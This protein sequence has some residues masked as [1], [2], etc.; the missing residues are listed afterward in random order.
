MKRLLED[1]K[2]NC[3]KQ[4]YLLCGEEAYL[5]LQY[6]DRLRNALA[7]PGDTM[8]YHYFEGKDTNPAELIDLSETVPFFAERRVIFVENSGFFKKTCEQLADY[9]KQLPPTTYFVF[10]ETEVDKRGKLYKAV[11]DTGRVVEFSSQDEETLKK[12][13]LSLIRKEGKKIS[14]AT[15]HYFLQKT[16]TDMGNIRRELEKVFC[17]TLDREAILQED[18]DAVCTR[19]V[20]NQIFD[21]VD[22]IAL[23][24]Q[25]EALRLYYDLLSLKEKP[26]RIL[27]LVGRQFNLLLQVKE[28]RKKGYAGRQIAEKTAIPVFFVGKYISQASAFTEAWLRDALEACVQADEAVKTGR[29]GD[30]MSVE[31][32]LISYSGGTAGNQAARH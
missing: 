2:N 13:V 4:V 30:V 27:A 1:I 10:I 6:R 21:M 22:A 26:M 15:L 32:L 20:S 8:N 19:L 29:L 25:Q 17:Y 31:L 5:R 11:R 28:L 18:I 23:Q 3:L 7:E 24:K 16:G 14:G 12:W 9:L